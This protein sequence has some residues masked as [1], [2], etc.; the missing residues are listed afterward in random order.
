MA[1]LEIVCG[2]LT[3]VK[4]LSEVYDLDF[5]RVRWRSESMAGRQGSVVV[6]VPRWR[7]E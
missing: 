6:I 4:I 3:S 2:E 1:I 5:E 7:F